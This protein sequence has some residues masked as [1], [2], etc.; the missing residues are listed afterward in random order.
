MNC[1]MFR[2]TL[3]TESTTIDRMVEIAFDGDGAPLPHTDVHAA[4]H[5]AVPAGGPHS[6][7]DHLHAAFQRPAG[8]VPATVT[9]NNQRPMASLVSAAANPSHGETRPA[10]IAHNMMALRML[11][12]FANRVDH[13]HT[14]PR[15][16][17]SA[18]DESRT[19]FARSAISIVDSAAR[20]A[21]VHAR[22]W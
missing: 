14:V 12:T 16:A 7:V 11:R 10:P 2:K 3:R 18:R 5:R 8:V 19:R 4:T 15:P 21:T 22:R 9:K 6:T 20:L 13:S 1:K 17:R